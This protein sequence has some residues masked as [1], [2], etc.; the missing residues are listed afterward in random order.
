L[1]R[2]RDAVAVDELEAVVMVSPDR[3]ARQFAYQYIVTEEF[4]QAGCEVIFLSQPT[5]ITPAERM[6][7]EMTGVFAEY[8][9]AQIVERCRRGRLFWARQGRLWMTEAPF[10]YTFRP[11]T[12]TCP[13][14]LV[15]NDA[16]AE[17]VRQL[18]RWLVEE[19]LSTYQ[20]VQRLN[21]L[22]YRTRR[23]KRHWHSG[24]VRNLLHN[25]V[26]QGTFYYNR[27]KQVK[28]QRRNLPTQEPLKLTGKGRI[29]RPRDEWI[30]VSVPAII[31]PE[32]WEAALRQLQVNR[33]RSPRN[34]ATHP[35]LLRSLLVCA[36]CNLRMH[37]HTTGVAGK[38]RR[39]LC[40]RKESL[41]NYPKP[42]PGRTLSADMIEEL[43]WDTV[44]HLL[45]HPQ[46]LLDHYRLR[47]EPSAETPEQHEGQRLTRRLQALAREEQR[48]VDA[49]QVE[50]INLTELKERR[51]RLAEERARV[52]TRLTVLQQHR[53]EQARHAV[54]KESLDAFCQTMRTALANPSFETKQKILRLVVEKI[55]VTDDCIT[56]HHMIPLPDIRLWRDHYGRRTPAQR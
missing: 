40:S 19:Q 47:Y 1:D 7:R 42:C 3:L 29:R 13:G 46:L 36:Y 52:T 28:A 35:Y 6:F 37:G 48:L 21:A 24:Y 39:Y 14:T 11:R 20:I 43:V 9:R 27:S 15:I 34:N 2:L 41:R 33:D 30:A 23:G 17:I 32:V 38:S 10:G 8:E 54:V 49:Y 44:R 50:V 26:Y 45:E 18:F 25:P 22:K 53:Q 4:E 31:E 51:E 55:V 12:E 5:A 16:E 56:I